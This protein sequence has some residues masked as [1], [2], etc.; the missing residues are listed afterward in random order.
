MRQHAKTDDDFK[1]LRDRPDFKAII[2]RMEQ[3]EQARKLAS[4]AATAATP[5]E[6]LKAAEQAEAIREKLAVEE[7]AS[8][9]R[10]H[11]VVV[12]LYSLGCRPP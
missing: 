4:D 10:Q 9:R 8:L 1:S 12:S 6:K 7:P 11:D 2:A 5:A 3:A